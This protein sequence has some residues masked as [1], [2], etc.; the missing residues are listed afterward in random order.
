M[1]DLAFS[2]VKELVKVEEMKNIFNTDNELF[3]KLYQTRE[4]DK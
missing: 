1:A 2:V 3:T 4:L